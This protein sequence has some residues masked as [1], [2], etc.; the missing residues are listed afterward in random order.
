MIKEACVESFTEARAAQQAGANRIELC[1][2]LTVGGTTPSYGTIKVCC[3]ELKIPV[4]AMIRPRGGNFC[5]SDDEFRIMKEDIGVCRDLGVEAVVFGL[6]TK[7]KKIDIERTCVLVELAQPMHT[8]FHKAFDE[9]ADPFEAI[10]QLISL[11]I[12]RIL[13][14]GTCE[15]AFEGQEMLRKLIAQVDGR[16]SIV[17]AGKITS[18]NLEILRELIP[19]TEFH[20]KRI[21]N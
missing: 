10:E 12:T 21:V 14:S 17:V 16:I 4:A 1:E 9:T 11:G 13:T 2:N 20:G 15:T 7:E 8:V 18:E 5:Y 3:Q 6:L 19:A